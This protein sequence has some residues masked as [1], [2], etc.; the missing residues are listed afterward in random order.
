MALDGIGSGDAG[1]AL[2]RFQRIRDSARKKLEGEER[3]AG[4]TELV[5]RKQS[6]IGAGGGIAP[7]SPAERVQP[8]PE[9][10]PAVRAAMG[11]S[12]SAYG[13]AGGA[14]NPDPKPK[15]GRFVDFM[16]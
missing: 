3:Q 7:R 6:E 5:R 4:L 2:E 1:S 16:A 15:L 11:Q 9:A 14:D 12:V 8:A 13:R 10:K